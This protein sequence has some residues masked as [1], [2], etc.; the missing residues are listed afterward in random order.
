MVA[1]G[2][3]SAVT[4]TGAAIVA[5]LWEVKEKNQAMSIFYVGI[6]LGPTLGPILGGVLTQQW[7]WRATQWFTTVY[8]ALCLLLV[9]FFL[10]ET[11]QDKIERQKQGALKAV[12]ESSRP[13][14]MGSMIYSAVLH[15]LRI[16]FFLKSPAITITIYLAS[17]TFLVV[18]ALQISFQ[19]SFSSQPYNFSPIIIGLSFLPFSIGLIIG[20]LGGGKWSDFVMGKTA[21]KTNR[22][23]EEGAIVNVPEDRIGLN[24]WVA[25]LL[26]PMGLLWYGWS[27]DKGVFWIMPV[28]ETH[29]IF[30]SV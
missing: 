10:P 8:G 15:P 16:I 20:D 29:L 13:P 22:Y 24:A 11:C 4:P 23:D 28:S 12:Q 6:L 14:A 18:K 25:T 27:I 5:D 3:G 26:F 1:S 19:K 9:V 7:D 2:A 30:L 17:I 21:V